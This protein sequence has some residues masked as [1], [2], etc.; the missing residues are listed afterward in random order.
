MKKIMMRKVVSELSLALFFVAIAAALFI[1][2]CQSEQNK[3]AVAEMK[4]RLSKEANSTDFDASLEK[5]K[6]LGMMAA[7]WSQ[8]EQDT[9]AQLLVAANKNGVDI[10]E[11]LNSL[12]Y[13]KAET[14]SKRARMLWSSEE[15][16]GL[17][18]EDQLVTLMTSKA[19]MLS[20]IDYN[21]DGRTLAKE[22]NLIKSWGPEKFDEVAGVS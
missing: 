9:L 18:T 19:G 2:G 16:P 20:L 12:G 3:A 11:G 13:I 7:T 5:I 21:V 8:T 4:E 14:L 6:F 10:T 22:A 1:G 17:L 15:L